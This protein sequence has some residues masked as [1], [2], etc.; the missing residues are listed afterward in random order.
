MQLYPPSDSAFTT[1]GEPQVCGRCQSVSRL[2]NGLCLNCLLKGALAEDEEPSDTETF[3][4]I[5]A[6]VN[7]RDGDWHIA[8]H[9]IIHEIARGG[10]G[11]VYQ[12]R[13]PHSGRIV[14]LKCVL[15]CQDDADQVVTRFRREAE[16]AA[17]LDHPNIVPIYQVGETADGFPFY[18]M[19]YAAGGSLLQARRPLLE[20]PRKSAAL[21]VKV[22][23]A[24]HYAHGQGVLHRDLKPGNIL[25][26]SHGEPLVT[27]FGLARC[28]AVSSYLTRSLASFGTPGYIAPEQADGPAANLTPAADV[29]S[30][31]AILFELLAGRTPF[32]GEN[33]FAVMKQSAHEP[34]P[35][36]RTLAPDVDRD[37]ETICDRCLER[38]PA[39]RYQSAAELADDLQSWLD[40]R[41]IRARRPGSW[42]QT[43]RWVRQNRL[44]AA[45]LAALCVIGAASFVWYVRTERIT[46]AM[47]ESRLASRSVVVLPFLDLDNVRE[48]PAST[49]QVM[50]A[51]SAGLRVFGPARVRAGEVP[52]WRKLEELQKT[53]QAL[54]ARTILTGT[55]RN[56]QG[57]K[58]ISVRLLN[59]A[60]GKPLFVKVLEQS[61]LKASPS[62][63]GNAWAGKIYAMLTTENWTDVAESE[64]DPGVLNPEAK[65][66][67]D[68]GQRALQ[69][70]YTLTELDQAIPLFRK[71]ISLEPKSARAHCYLAMAAAAR[72]YFNADSTYLE[73][74]KA[75]ARTAL[76][77]A[78]DSPEA[79]RALAGAYFQDG[80]FEDALVEQIKALEFGGITDRMC[81]FLGMVLDNLGRPDRALSWNQIAETLQTPPG[82]AAR[83]IGDSWT[84]LDDDE[85]AF[86]A[87]D[88]CIELEP[89]AAQGAV[90]KCRLHL[91]RGEDEA[92]RKICSSRLRNQ[93][94]LGEMAQIAAQLEFFSGNYP[95]AR[96]LYSKLIKTDERGGGSFYGAVTYQSALGR[97]DQE[98]G[99]YEEAS[100]LFEQALAAE[101]QA[102]TR[103]PRNSEAAYRLAAVEACL[104]KSKIALE[105]LRQAGALGW[106]DYRSLKRDP[107]FDSL[108]DNPE[109]NTLIDGLSAKVAELRSNTP[110]K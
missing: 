42:R 31:G 22:A 6:T 67:L 47:N 55:V 12:A 78:P 77:L 110:R 28:E 80:Q 46:L 35:K 82:E 5:L 58:R 63:V 33:A 15:A 69:G 73:L 92:A 21:M 71:A 91:L 86:R 72:T 90:G 106:L 102:F 39:D 62:D 61:E 70:S 83:A 108:R 98:L 81:Q 2:T 74:A 56:V 41:P 17:R 16:T 7:S 34:A 44:L 40:D 49:R 107:R 59:P 100:R 50:D 11:V 25:L 65:N 57:R 66:N 105:H 24:I 26:D 104:G 93:S 96:E 43:R 48:D 95:Q 75:E 1:L 64:R 14:A 76:E 79:H 45:A 60:D 13:E 8:E 68:A 87:Y 30:L 23:R 97:I 10:M 84:K 51:L 53:A 54:G 101:T 37:L 36:L 27:D 89:G 32:V 4:E 18:T 3:K 38:E 88:R 20:H 29:Y 85:Q 94:E 109:L 103:Q 52:G 9:L 19:K 99:A